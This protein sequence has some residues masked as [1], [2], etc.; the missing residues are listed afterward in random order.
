MNY[1]Q[2]FSK[3]LDPVAKILLEADDIDFAASIL[4]YDKGDKNKSRFKC[5][6]CANFKCKDRREQLHHIA[7]NHLEKIATVEQLS[8]GLKLIWQSKTDGQCVYTCKTG[9]CDF[10]IESAYDKKGHVIRSHISGHF[11]VNDELK[12][13]ELKKTWNI[14]RKD[15]E[16]LKVLKV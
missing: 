9:K 1:F 7:Q 3:S 11:K 16:K 13:E 8:A 12:L 2:I 10:A 4:K 15:L 14:W 5:A 6:L